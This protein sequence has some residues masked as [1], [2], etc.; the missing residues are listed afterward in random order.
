MYILFSA[1]PRDLQSEWMRNPH[2]YLST[3]LLFSSQLSSPFSSPPAAVPPQIKFDPGTLF[4]MHLEV[5]TSDGNT[6]RISIGNIFKPENLKK[7]SG[8]VQYNLRDPPT[9]WTLLSIDLA[10]AAAEVAGPAAAAVKFSHLK[11]IQL[12]SMLSVRGAFTSDI[13][14][15]V[16]VRSLYCTFVSALVPMSLL[17]HC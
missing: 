4:S 6:C 17:I 11:S 3:C 2:P 14:F 12:C 5:V 15:G 13:R 7:K 9:T 8:V 10:A 1:I 16:T